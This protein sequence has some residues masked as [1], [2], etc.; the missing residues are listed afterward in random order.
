MAMK[1]F[2]VDWPTTKDRVL[3]V[4]FDLASGNDLISALLCKTVD[5][6]TAVS[7]EALADWNF[8]PTW[9]LAGVCL[10]GHVSLDCA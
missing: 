5:R 10:S 4:L 8:L 2:S 1:A 7:G 6:S 9:S 3:E